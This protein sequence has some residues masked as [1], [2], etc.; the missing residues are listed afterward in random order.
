MNRLVR[1]IPAIV[2]GSFSLA[3]IIA[4]ISFY[5]ALS[6]VN[7]PFPGFIIYQFARVGSL[8]ETEWTGARAGIKLQDKIVSVDGRPVHTGGQIFDYSRKVPPGTPIQYTL[9]D[10]NQTKS[11]AVPTSI[12]NFKDFIIVFFL[13]YAGGL[14]LLIIGLIVYIIKPAMSSSWIFYLFCFNIGVY[15][16]TA[17]EIQTTYYFVVIHYLLTAFQGS[18]FF[19]LG[20]IFPEKKRIKTLNKSCT[21]DCID[22]RWN[23]GVRPVPLPSTVVHSRCNNDPQCPWGWE[24][25]F[26]H[27]GR[28]CK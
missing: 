26:L 11:I 19:H 16:N 14:A 21:S 23:N 27:R 2:Y 18:M 8:G 25:S 3:M 15:M 12:F 9:T 1:F 17:V 24:T 28:Q 10:K 5:L 6:L 20:L 13:P 22:M 4:A 7:R